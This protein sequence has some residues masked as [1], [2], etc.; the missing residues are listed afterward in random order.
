MLSS[1]LWHQSLIKKI[2]LNSVLVS[3]AVLAVISAITAAFVW[4]RQTGIDSEK[5]KQAIKEAGE[6][7]DEAKKWANRPAD[8]D[9]TIVRL[10]DLAKRKD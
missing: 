8:R 5:K 4:S 9:A 3:I 6:A 7:F 2:V 1:A 10:R